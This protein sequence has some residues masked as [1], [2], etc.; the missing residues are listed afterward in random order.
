MAK[1]M[2]ALAEEQE[3]DVNDD[4]SPWPPRDHEVFE[5]LLEKMRPLHILDKLYDEG[6]I[7]KDEWIEL[8]IVKTERKNVE[9]LIGVILPRKSLSRDVFH[10]VCIILKNTNSQEEVAD[11]LLQYARMLCPSLQQST[12]AAYVWIATHKE[13]LLRIVKELV[14][15]VFRQELNILKEN[16]SFFPSWGVADCQPESRSDTAAQMV[17]FDNFFVRVILRGITVAEF[18]FETAKEIFIAVIA[19]TFNVPHADIERGLRVSSLESVGVSQNGGLGMYRDR[20]EEILESENKLP[21]LTQVDIDIGG[22]P[23]W[24]LPLSSPSDGDLKVRRILM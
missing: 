8:Q 4:A 16:I 3:N 24:S 5:I 20:C 23:V 9:K 1:S 15:P 6:L 10:K 22:L 11:I 17:V 21:Q 13:D 18:E 7:T 14:V 19:D 12:K 2:A